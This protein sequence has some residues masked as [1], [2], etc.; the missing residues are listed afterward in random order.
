MSRDQ[1]V[2]FPMPNSVNS[3]LNYLAT[4]DGIKKKVQFNGANV[5]VDPL[6][7]RNLPQR[8]LPIDDQFSQPIE[9]IGGDTNF[10]M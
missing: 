8:M 2:F 6:S 1:F 9:E 7:H 10:V 3:R 5:V 4:L